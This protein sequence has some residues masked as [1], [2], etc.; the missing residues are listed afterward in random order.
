MRRNIVPTVLSEVYRHAEED[1]VGW[2]RARGYNVDRTKSYHDNYRLYKAHVEKTANEAH[3]AALGLTPENM[4]EEMMKYIVKPK[5]RKAPPPPPPPPAPVHR[6]KHRRH[7]PTY[8][9]TPATPV[10][11]P[12]PSQRPVPETIVR[13]RPAPSPPPPDPPSPPPAPVGRQLPGHWEGLSSTRRW[14]VFDDMP[15]QLKERY[16]PPPPPKRVNND[17]QHIWG[18][19]WHK[20]RKD[21]RGK[22][23]EAAARARV[24]R[25]QEGPGHNP[26]PPPR[27]PIAKHIRVPANLSIP[28]TFKYIREHAPPGY[29]V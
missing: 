27:G 28:D 15:S 2:M 22:K 10:A 12:P 20:E 25:R 19:A 21:Q 24:E 14:Y 3:G 16:S 1:S 6:H 17:A 26:G 11:P 13:P 7:K 23:G 18:G 9:D 8:D 4:R 29:D 5:R